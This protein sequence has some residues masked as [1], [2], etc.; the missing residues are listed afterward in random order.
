MGVELAVANAASHWTAMAKVRGWQSIEGAG[1]TAV[2]ADTVH[3]VLLAAG[4]PSDTEA[5]RAELR[6]LFR[7]W[8]SSHACVEDPTRTL[9]LS[10]LGFEAAL[11]MPVMIRPPGPV[12]D[13]DGL[14]HRGDPERVQAGEARDERDLAEV[15]RVVVEGFPIARHQPWRRGGHFPACDGDIAGR[16]SWLA[17]VDGRP[18]AACITHDDGAAV[19]LYWVATL[20][21]HRSRGAAR[22]LLRA[23]L[24]AH[25]DRPATLTATLLG[26]PLY[27]RLGFVEGGLA[28]WWQFPATTAAPRR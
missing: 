4:P 10:D 18:A 26:E 11:A 27:R 13:G 5:L 8:E 9:D 28:R 15:E 7:R 25:P 3:R 24:A 22:A 23:A 14:R 6:A 20:P 17:H 19:G 16:R 12:V 2:R 21:D 1:F